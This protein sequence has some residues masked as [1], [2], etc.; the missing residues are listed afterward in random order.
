MPIRWKEANIK[1]KYVHIVILGTKFK[2]IMCDLRAKI[3]LLWDVKHP[4]IL[5][6]I[7]YRKSMYNRDFLSYKTMYVHCLDTYWSHSF[8]RTSLSIIQN[9]MQFCCTIVQKIS[10]YLNVLLSLGCLWFKI[11]IIIYRKIIGHMMSVLDQWM[12][13]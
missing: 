7:V 9:N 6:N 5:C 1:S 2:E 12:E 10:K 4:F 13:H 8:I 11:I 3:W